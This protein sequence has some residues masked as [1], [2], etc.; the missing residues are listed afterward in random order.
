M[1]LTT[2]AEAF[3]E[4]DWHDYVIVQTIEFTNADAA[5]D[6]PYPMSITEIENMTIA[7]KRMAAM[8]METTAEDVEALRAKQAAA[9]A[10]AAAAVGSVGLIEAPDDAAMAVENAYEEAAAVERIRREMEA[11]EH[12]LERAK[13]IQATSLDATGPIKIRTDYVPKR[14]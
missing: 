9:E 14:E 1:S 12:E 7:Q 2:A 11:R 3:A 5:T 13:A 8:V 4:I 10:N 6:L